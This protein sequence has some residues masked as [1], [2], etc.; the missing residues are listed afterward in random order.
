MR[1]YSWNINGIRAAVGKGFERW[2]DASRP[3]V[4]C[5]QE[6]RV[7]PASVPDALR[8]LAGYHSY[9]APMRHKGYGGVATFCREPAGSWRAR[10]G[11]TGLDDEGRVLITDIGDI[12]VYN[13]YFPNG[14]ASPAPG[15]QAR[16][17]CRL[18]RPHRR[19]RPIGALRR[20][21]RRCQYRASSY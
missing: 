12:S 19:P 1:L 8:H 11:A 16:L 6:T 18:P 3:E 10:L 21:L 17:L 20:L 2:L 7:D 5:L 13:V 15:L 4:L 9:W 14:K